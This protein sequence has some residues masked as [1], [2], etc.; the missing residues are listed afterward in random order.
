VCGLLFA[1]AGVAQHPAGQDHAGKKRLQDQ[2]LSECLHHD[3]G[4]GS[5]AA[6]AAVF[7]GKRQSQQAQ[8][9]ILVPH[10]L[11]ETGVAGAILAARLE[12]VLVLQQAFHAVLQHGLFFGKVK[13]HFGVL[14]TGRPRRR[15]I[16]G[17]VAGP[18][19]AVPC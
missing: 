2:R 4:L 3:H 9:G 10:L 16:A 6:D 17:L 11:A 18:L 5:A 15:R 19:N 8:F 13:V 7:L 1:A 12:T 14:P